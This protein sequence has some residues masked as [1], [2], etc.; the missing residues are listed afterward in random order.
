ML[1][2]LFG[3]LGK[4]YCLYFYVLSAMSFSLFLLYMLYIIILVIKTPSK[5]NVPFLMHSLLVIMYSLLVYFVNRL[6]YTMCIN[7]V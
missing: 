7:S 6:L 1:D 4:D 5:M 2:T 3:P